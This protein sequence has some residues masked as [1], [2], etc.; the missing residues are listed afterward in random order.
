MGD[1]LFGGAFDLN[2]DGRLD[3]GEA[4]LA[5]ALFEEEL[6]GNADGGEDEDEE[7]DD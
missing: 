4:A 1:D 6:D 2:D 5:A 3:C 7:E